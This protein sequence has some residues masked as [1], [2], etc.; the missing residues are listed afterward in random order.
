MGGGVGLSVHGS[1]RVATETTMFAMPE[2]AIGF[3]TD[4]G[5][6]YFLSRLP[7]H[8]GMYLGL[9][10]NRLKGKQ[11][12][13][14]GIATHF[15]PKADLP[16]LEQL[17]VDADTEDPEQLSK[18]ISERFP[19]ENATIKE[20]FPDIDKI[21]KVFKNETVDGIVK[22]LEQINDEWSQGILKTLRSVSPTS[23]RVVN[24][25]INLGKHLSFKECFLMEEG[26]AHQMMVCFLIQL[27][28]INSNK[29]TSLKV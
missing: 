24:R 8:L 28:N 7:K 11:V 26:I 1:I 2:T 12:L 18:L 16:A 14:A 6:S 4:V 20:Q 17:I 29:M 22:A 3:F 10:G 9:T 15:V 25:Q 21:E 27:S 23:L 5:G 13:A 19:V